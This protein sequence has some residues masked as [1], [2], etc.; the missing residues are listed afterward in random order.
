MSWCRR[1][2][3]ALCIVGDAFAKPIADALDR[4]PE[5]WDLGGVRVLFS[6][7]VV[8]SASS[9][10]RLLAHLPRATIVDSLGSSET[11]SVARSLSS[12]DDQSATDPTASFRVGR[13]TRVVDEHGHDVEPGSG[14]I[15]RVVLAG[16]LPSGYYKDPVKTAETFVPIDGTSHVVT[17]DWAEVAGDGTL[18]FLGRGSVSIN[19]GGEKVYPEEVEEAIKVVAGVE[20]AIVVGIP[21]DRLGEVVAA[22]VEPTKGATVDTALVLGTLRRSLAG[23]KI[24]RLVVQQP[25]ARAA[26]GKADYRGLRDI[27]IDAARSQRAEPDPPE[28]QPR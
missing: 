9:K 19:T 20:D 1:R 11:G 25:I 3:R 26:N 17:G 23:F 14:H 28:E 6:S 15:G 22:I 7:G 10:S 27:A 8:L 24:P 4:E 16:H 21:D 2:S 18:R 13:R 12:A 5:R